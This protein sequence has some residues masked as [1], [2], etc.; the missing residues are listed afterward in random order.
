MAEAKRVHAFRDDAL[1][2]LDG[3]ALA[4][5]VKSGEVSPRELIEAAI[6][7]IE[8][9]NPSLNAV[10]LATYEQALTAASRARMDGPF[11]GV[12]SFI[13][14]N[15]DL[16][17][18]PT[19]H[20]S[21]ATTSVP[22]KKNGAFAAQ[23]M[24]QGFAVMGKTRLPEF[25]FNCTTEYEHD[26]PVRNPWHTDYSC[27]GSSGGSA[28]LVA[29]GVVPLAHA[30]DGGGS[31]RIPA[32]CCGL[33]G[34]KSTRG[35]LVKSEMARTLPVNIVSEG[36]VSR[37]VRDT[38][39]FLAGAER[40]WR[41]RKLPPVGLVEGPGNRRLRIGM[42]VDSITGP[43]CP[44]TRLAV[45]ETGALLASAGHSVEPVPLPVGEEFVEDFADYWGFLAF[46]ASRFGQLGLG[47]GFDASQLDGLSKGLAR[48]FQRRMYRTPV[49]LYRLQRSWQQ[50]AQSLTDFDLI[51]TP[52][53]GHVTP[54]LGV[55][56]P[57]QPFDELFIRLMRYVS[58]T[59]VNNANGS[60][61][62]SLPMGMSKEEGLPV[63]VQLTARHGDER[64]LLEIAY[65]LEATKPWRRIDQAE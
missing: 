65:E 45:E 57:D 11:A 52:V 6:G 5:R 33:V 35:R 63:A 20:G 59:P 50:H 23:F 40:Y 9:V 48:R 30:N 28:A 14:D 10:E 3:V 43:S 29:A 2:T 7:R 4:Q 16:A 53:L 31:I 19:R 39:H 34:L 62:I 13:K 41:N 32:A 58:F 37:S 15:T 44:E 60:P 8:Q 18:L 26:E 27:G 12:P 49:V 55:M 64:T 36:V 47:R 25:G 46:M 42:I 24:A 38:A 51:L 1:G 21:R 17:G 61:A 54:R 22:A 56:S